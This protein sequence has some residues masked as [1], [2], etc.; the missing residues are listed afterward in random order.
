MGAPF[1]PDPVAVAELHRRAAAL[2]RLAARLDAAAV[3]D[4]LRRAGP[5]VWVGP[6][7]D[8]FVAD[9]RVQRASMIGSADELQAL[10]RMLDLR[11]AA[12]PSG[13]ATPLVGPR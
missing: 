1:V 3:N 6:V 7:A 12:I 13:A 4:L 11:A 9:L 2:R 8:D 10:A 5:D